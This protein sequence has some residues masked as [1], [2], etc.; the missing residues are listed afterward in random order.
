MDFKD[1]NYII[2]K[3]KRMKK[4]VFILVLILFT[5]LLIFMPRSR[6]KNQ[7]EDVHFWEVQSIDTMKYSR[8]VAREKLRDPSFDSVIEQQIKNIAESY[9]THVAIGTPYDDEFLPFLKRWVGM[10]RKYKLK[11]WFRGNWSGWEKWFG[12]PS[13]DR[14]AH[15]EKTVKFTLS[16]KDIFEDSDVFGACN[17]CENG[18]PGDPRHNG[19]AKGHKAF[20]IEEYKATKTAFEKIDKKIASN[21]SSMNGDVANLI[22]DKETT[23]ALGGI[24]VVDHYVASPEQLI[25][26]IKALAKKSGGKIVLGEFGAPI[27]D[28]HGKM[29]EG[30]QSEWLEN[31]LQKLFNMEEVI[32]MNYWTNVGSS[33]ELWDAKGSARPA[34]EIIKKY[35]KRNLDRH[36]Y[37]SEE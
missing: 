31:V 1:K 3:D 19:D 34:V 21:Y 9:A 22:M 2:Q 32:G 26:D 6:N 7:K 25:I 4:T 14:K 20:L 36:Q 5:L 10:A 16:N 28:I 8:D 35:Y 18:G 15:I 23:K 11:V 30:E 27:P 29:S 12:Y 13:I 17:E 37:T 33:T 24:V